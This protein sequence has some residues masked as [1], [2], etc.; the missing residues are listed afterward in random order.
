MQGGGG[1]G[2]G[3]VFLGTRHVGSWEWHGFGSV[4]DF[5]V[6]NEKNP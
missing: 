2:G 4:D 3:G 5:Q 1:G 6:S